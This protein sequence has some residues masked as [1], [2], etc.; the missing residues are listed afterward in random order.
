[1]SSS[2]GLDM[3]ASESTGALAAEGG[4]EDQLTSSVG[5]GVGGR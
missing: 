1:M 2:G 5:S 4:E 3:M